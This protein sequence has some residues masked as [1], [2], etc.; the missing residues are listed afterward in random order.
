MQPKDISVLEMLKHAKIMPKLYACQTLGWSHC[1]LLWNSM[2]VAARSKWSLQRGV[3]FL[4]ANDQ[5]WTF[6]RHWAHYLTD[7]FGKLVTLTS[8]LFVG[9]YNIRVHRVVITLW[10]SPPE[11][12][13]QVWKLRNNERRTSRTH[14]TCTAREMVEYISGLHRHEGKESIGRFTRSSWWYISVWGPNHLNPKPLTC[15]KGRSD[16]KSFLVRC[17]W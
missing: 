10:K 2:K 17:T 8:S 9:N 3:Q 11:I 16:W 12:S 6:K 15:Q 4:N 13:R 7:P 1:G 5:A 14:P